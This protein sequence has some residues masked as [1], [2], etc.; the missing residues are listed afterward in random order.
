MPSNSSPER[1][2][3]TGIRLEND[4]KDDRIGEY[5]IAR[6]ERFSATSAQT[7]S[8]FSDPQT[9]PRLCRTSFSFSGS[10]SVWNA[11][12]SH[13]SGQSIDSANP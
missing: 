12:A 9:N 4:L 2:Q 13:N 6:P 7:A 11:P 3:G 1:G 10:H 5:Q 8:R